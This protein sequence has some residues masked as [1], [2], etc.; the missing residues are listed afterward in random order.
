MLRS[1]L[2]FRIVLKTGYFTFPIPGEMKVIQNMIRKL[3]G[4]RRLGWPLD[5]PC[6]C[7]MSTWKHD[8]SG[9]EVEVF[10]DPMKELKVVSFTFLLVSFLSGNDSTYQIRKKVFFIS[11]QKLFPFSRKSNFRILHFQISWRHQMPKHKARNKFHWITWA[12][13]NSLLMKFGQFMSH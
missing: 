6:K 10:N 2:H 5:R 12:V 9:K 1:F 13:N 11:L 7:N 3:F 8:E 4:R